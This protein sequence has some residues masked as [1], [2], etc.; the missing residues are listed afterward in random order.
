LKLVCPISSTYEL[1]FA[2]SNP[3]QLGGNQLLLPLLDPFQRDN[4]MIRNQMCLLLIGKEELDGDEHH[5]V[6]E[7]G[8]HQDF[9]GH[10]EEEGS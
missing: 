4:L 5:V 10:K 7:D 6:P 1:F 8:G 9:Q 2:F 3:L